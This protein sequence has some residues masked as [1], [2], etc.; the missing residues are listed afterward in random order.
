M[1]ADDTKLYTTVSNEEDSTVL[2]GDL[3]NLKDWS[4]KWQV[5]FSASKCKVIHLG[6]NIR[7]TYKMGNTKLEETLEKGLGVYIYND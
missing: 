6:K 7:F 1:F 2:Q 5:C 3:K 4:H